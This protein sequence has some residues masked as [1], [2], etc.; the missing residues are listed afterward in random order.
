MTIPGETPSVPEL[1][2]AW[3][4]AS[5]DLLALVASLTDEEWAAP[6]PCP[7]WTVADIVAHGI[8]I[9]QTVA[10]VPRP[11]HV[12]DSAS[13]SHVRSPIGEFT[14]IGVDMRRGRPREELLTEYREILTERR[15]QLDGT[16]ADAEVMGP[17]GRM[18][19]LER[20]LRVR[21]FDVWVHEQDVR[22]AT[23]RDGDWDTPGAVISFQQMTR[24]VPFAW[25]RNVQAP[26]GATVR[27]L[28]T[29]PELTG[30]V[31]AVVGADGEGVPT[32]PSGAATVSLVAPWRDFMRLACGRIYPADPGLRS[33][34][35]LSG[36]E[37]L[38]E[39]LLTGLS[40]TP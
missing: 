9:E 16:P 34:I 39:A 33:R 21:T 25:G 40:I 13:R 23:G 36:D 2:D 12:V 17:L 37:A 28:V 6:T 19:T 11:T 5:T 35:D 26:P 1:I 24:A 15:R 7:G 8:D 4:S 32:E 30:E 20:L 10:G 29:G 22:T 31:W 14:E 27:V 38:R 3:H 18:T